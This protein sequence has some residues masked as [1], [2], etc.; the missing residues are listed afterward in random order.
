MSVIKRCYWRGEMVDCASIFV[1]RSTDRGMCCTFNPGKA[2]NIYKD[3]KYTRIISDM[4]QQD[5]KLH[6]VNSML[7]ERYVRIVISEQ[8]F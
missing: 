8:S 4:Q 3:T 2:E 5:Q 6:F 1:T 7:L